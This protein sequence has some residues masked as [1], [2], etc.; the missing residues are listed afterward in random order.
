M[1]VGL[2]YFGVTHGLESNIK[3]ENKDIR[4]RHMQLF[5]ALRI[6]I[7]KLTSLGPLTRRSGMEVFRWLKLVLEYRNDIAQNYDI[8]D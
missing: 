5:W 7:E 6:I 2:L 4:K 3:N 1:E 8:G